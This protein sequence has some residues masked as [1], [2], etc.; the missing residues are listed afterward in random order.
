MDGQERMWLGKRSE[1]IKCTD[2]KKVKTEKHGQVVI[3][4]GGGSRRQSKRKRIM[5]CYC[6]DSHVTGN[7]IRLEVPKGKTCI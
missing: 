7:N 3:A 2:R 6:P 1:L 4:T 5:F